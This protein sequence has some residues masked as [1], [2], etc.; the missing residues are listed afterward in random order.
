[1]KKNKKII[2]VDFDGTLCEYNFPKI[3]NQT[4]EQKKLLKILIEMRKSGHKI[5]LW[6][7]RGDNEKYPV[8]TEAV[9]WCKNQGLEFDAINSN[10]K[11]QKKLSG[12]SPKIMADYYIDDKALAF[13]TKE[14]MD[15]VLNFLQSLEKK[16]A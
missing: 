10:L 1:M 4:E 15:F 12:P 8:L 16:H 3:G 14:S 11:G 2:A 6:T 7:N 9:N 13:K 5:I